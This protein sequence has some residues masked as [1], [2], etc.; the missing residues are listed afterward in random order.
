MANVL[1]HH[2][3]EVYGTKGESEVSWFEASPD[4]SIEII[5]CTGI[6]KSAPIIDVGAGISRLPDRLVE[7]GYTDIT[8]LDISTEAVRRLTDRLPADAPVRGVVA[9]V[10]EWRPD[11]TYQVWHDRAVLHFL[12]KEVDRAGYRRALNSGLATGGQAIIATFALSGPER[13]SG[14]PVQRYS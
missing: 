7:R 10:T 8:V 11:R 14:L 3:N 2:W 1:Q 5:A 9:D 13:C 12:T 6:D 4:T